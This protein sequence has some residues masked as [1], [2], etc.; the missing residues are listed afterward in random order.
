MKRAVFDEQTSK[1]LKKWHMNAQK[2]KTEGKQETVATT[3]TLGD[4]SSPKTPLS[5]QAEAEAEADHRLPVAEPDTEQQPFNQAANIMAT[6]DLQ[7]QKNGSPPDL[8]T[9]P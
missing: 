5:G 7:D 3:R 1:A 6:I 8:L 2:K 4:D 9:G